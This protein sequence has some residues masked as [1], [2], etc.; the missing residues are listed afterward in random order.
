MT[1]AIANGVGYIDAQQNVDGSF[2]TAGPNA[3]TAFAVIAYGVL[4]G[5]NPSNLTATQQT[6]LANAVTYLLGQ[7][8][9]D[10]SFDPTYQ[11]YVTGLA[12][13]GLSLS[14]TI[15]PGI[16]TAISLGRSWL[17]QNQQAPQSVTGNPLSQDCSSADQ[18]PAG[19]GTDVYCGGWNYD[20]GPTR[21]DESNT[22][23]ALTGLQLSG[24]V[25]AATA[26]IDIGWQTHI[27]ELQST[28]YFA[29]RNDGGGAY[30]V[31]GSFDSDANDTGS[32]L[33]GLGYD[34]VAS[35]DAKVQAAL[36]FARDVL[37]EYEL[38]QGTTSGGQQLAHNG[39]N[40]DGTCDLTVS[41]CDW[42]IN[43]D[44]GFHYSLWSL[45][46]GFGQYIAPSLTDTTNWYAKVIDLLLTQQGGDGSWPVDGRDDFS[47]IVATSFAV[48]ALG[49]TGVPRTLTVTDAGTG[50][51]SVTSSPTRIDCGATC[52]ASFTQGSM[53]ILTAT[54]ATH[55]TF[56]GW[57]GAGCSGTGTCT[58]TM[59]QDR[60]VT[61]TF[62]A[63]THTLTVSK[64]GSG[65]GSVGSSPTG[66]DCGSTCSNSFAEGSP[67]TL[68][69]TASVGSVFA[70]WSGACSG[71]GACMVTMSADESV[72]ATFNTVATR[73][74]TVSKNGSGSGTV[75]SG[76]GGINCGTTCSSLYSDGAVVTLTASAP[77]GSIFAGWTGAC[78]GS[79]T[80]CMVT[81]SADESATATFNATT[82]HTLTVTKS[83]TGSGSVSSGDSTISCGA[84]C[85]A[86]YNQGTVV[87]LTA[88]PA[89]GSRFAGWSGGGCSG[90]GT[91][92][93]TMS[94]D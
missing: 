22:G 90:T 67:V 77:T 40:E 58:V 68:T 19:S 24:G 7:Q 37:N 83:G 14:G 56:T 1:T 79:S 93:V 16:A 80:T 91:C 38:E 45:T 85:S 50:T 3:E 10:G 25:P 64:S 94:A 70:G 8:A 29:A 78:S 42:Y 54:P 59:S 34:G 17:I 36:T 21:S 82:T 27:Q 9:A 11:T 57:S 66:I 44:G 2:G 72:T 47:P 76:D 71:T 46:K 84:T 53:V 4:D 43:G 74:L 52:S 63:I 92:M 51:G 23:F 86:I 12:V 30:D 31:Y 88:T 41:G 73:T 65:S 75:T 26:S 13:D 32:L 20:A 62:T 89:A 81:M 61:A 35:S 55:S 33:L 49:L 60:S 5:G 48:Q 28:N 18:P 87:T 15:V 39:M 69:P 6:H